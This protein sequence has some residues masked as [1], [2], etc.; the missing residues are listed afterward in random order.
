MDLVKDDPAPW[1]EDGSIAQ[2]GEVTFCAMVALTAIMDNREAG[3]Q[4]AS[5]TGRSV[6]FE[7]AAHKAGVRGVF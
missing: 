3:T 4:C 2:T 7:N 1:Q 5:T 6:S